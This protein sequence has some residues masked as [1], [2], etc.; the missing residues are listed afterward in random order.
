[1]MKREGPGGAGWVEAYL[2]LGS[3]QGDRV[4]MLARARQLLERPPVL[5]IVA[6][7]GLYETEPVGL[8]DQPWFLNQ[9]V[10]VRTG[11]S[12]LE[13]LAV[14]RQVE[15]ALGRRRL[16]RWG[17]RTIDVDMLLYGGEK[18]DGPDLEVPH[19]RMWE[20]AFVLAPLAELAPDLPVPGLTGETVAGLAKRL[21]RESG[22]VVRIYLGGG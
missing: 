20:R 22:K 1:M 5:Q 10:R 2:G 8:E 6:E 11:L 21:L 3:N 14:I 16:I 9:V 15:E 19:P 18:I 13:L 7:S 12:P 17:P 4:E